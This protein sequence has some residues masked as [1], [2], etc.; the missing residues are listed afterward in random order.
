MVIEGNAMQKYILTTICITLIPFIYEITTVKNVVVAQEY[1]GCFLI[2][3]AGTVVELDN[4]CVLDEEQ[5]AEPLEFT[6][7]EFQPPIAGLKS[8][9][10]Q[11]SV[12]NRSNKVI[13]LKTIYFQLV[14]NNRVI[15]A[16]DIPVET[17]NGLQPGESLSFNTG[18]SSNKVEK[19]SEDGIKV[20]VTRYE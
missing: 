15:A 3:K 11:G 20:E 12:T 18:I 5:T 6:G 8:G 14:A 13:P 19:L 1:P 9:G 7:L 17:G 16:S 10:V 2:T 4:L